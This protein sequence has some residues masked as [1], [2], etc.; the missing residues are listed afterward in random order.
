[1]VKKVYLLTMAMLVMTPWS[2]TVAISAPSAKINQ[3]W[4]DISSQMG[5]LGAMGVHSAASGAFNSTPA[6][7]PNAPADAGPR[8]GVAN[9]GRSIGAGEPGDGGNGIHA[10]TVGGL[11][12]DAA[13]NPFFPDVVTKDGTILTDPLLCAGTPGNPGPAAVIP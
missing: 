9:Q 10:I 8:L 1:M 2:T 7:G 11:V 3:C 13:A 4:G 6:A 5:Q 12:D